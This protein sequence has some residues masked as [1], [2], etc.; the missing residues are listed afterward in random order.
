MICE[1]SLIVS[2]YSV[3]LSVC[4]SC[5]CVQGQPGSETGVCA[6][7]QWP[8]PCVA[9]A[10]PRATNAGVCLGQTDPQ[11]QGLGAEHDAHAQGTVRSC[12]SRDARSDTPTFSGCCVQCR[13][14]NIFA[15]VRAHMCDSMHSIDFVVDPAE[16]QDVQQLSGLASAEGI[17]QMLSSCIFSWSEDACRCW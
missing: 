12:P 3:C 14:H 15:P 6:H 9:D 7:V 8:H 17:D 13:P 2:G 5:V 10:Q 11:P 1:Q 4:S 16:G